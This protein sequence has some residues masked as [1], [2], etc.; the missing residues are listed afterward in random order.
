M[1]A[2]GKHAEE[3]SKAGKLLATGG[4]LPLSKGARVRAAG[5]KVTVT[6]AV[7]YK[8]DSRESNWLNR[9]V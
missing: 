3:L 5:G 7:R 2:I 4:L 8:I 1:A 9:T 6:E